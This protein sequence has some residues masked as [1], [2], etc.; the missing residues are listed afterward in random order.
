MECGAEEIAIAEK[1]LDQ[2]LAADVARDYDAWL[3]PF[4]PAEPVDSDFTREYFETDTDETL[5]EAGVYKSREFLCCI[6]GDESSVARSLRFVWKGTYEKKEFIIIVGV[7]QRVGHW[8]AN[9][10]MWH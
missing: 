10:G 1:I 6:K 7:H 5:Q 3:V 2:M 4:D 8:Y 9:E